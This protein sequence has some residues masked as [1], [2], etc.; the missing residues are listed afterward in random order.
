MPKVA[1]N[2][3]H[4]AVGKSSCTKVQEFR[5][6]FLNPYHT[7]MLEYYELSSWCRIPWV[8]LEFKRKNSPSSKWQRCVT[9]PTWCEANE[10]R[11]VFGDAIDKT[12]S[13]RTALYLEYLGLYKTYES[14]FVLYEFFNVKTM[15][16]EQCTSPLDFDSDVLYRES[17]GAKYEQIIRKRLEAVN[18]YTWCSVG[19]TLDE[20]LSKHQHEMHKV[21]GIKRNVL[22]RTVYITSNGSE[23]LYAIPFD[24]EV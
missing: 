22:G 18:G 14:P 13:G 9:P 10:Y 8:Y 4:R 15:Q 16:W 3:T 20:A 7:M 2:N 19:D 21:V 11:W 17:P 24:V 5:K 12:Y 6:P 1:P 23:V